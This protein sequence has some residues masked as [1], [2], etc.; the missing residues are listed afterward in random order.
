MTRKLFNRRILLINLFAAVILV[1]VLYL[2][3]RLLMPKYMSEIPEGALVSEYY[4]NKGDNDIIFIG[5]CEAYENI[6]PITIWENY[7][8][9]S[10]IIGSGQ[11]LIWQSYY[12]LEEVLRYETPDVVVFNILAMQYDKPQ[13]EPYNRLNIDGMKLGVPKVKAA[14]ASMM[15]EET[16]ASYI[17]PLL[18]YHSRWQEVT[19]EDFEYL[20]KRDQKSHNGFLMRVDVKPVE[21]IPQARALAD[22]QFGERSYEYLDKMRALCEQ[23]GIKLVLMKAP[24]LFP[25]WY[26]EWETQIEEYASSNGLLY[27][28]YLE[29]ADD[30]S[31]DFS[32]DT[33]DA[34]LH[35]NLS[36]AEKLSVHLGQVLQDE[37][38]LSDRRGEKELSES[39][40]DKVQFYYD[41]KA[42]QY[43]DLEKYGY[44][45]NFGGRAPQG[46]EES[47]EK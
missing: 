47:V 18:R 4:K 9:P 28:N 7:G 13:S 25:Y 46:S 30:I 26:P 23:N 33:Y 21:S 42:S 11:Q 1:I 12:M 6:S 8:V 16:L 10:Y 29:L 31:L 17:F 5:D 36:G 24:S 19:K 39:W 32:E 20:F 45:K 37:Y 38:N 3:Q 44:L 41:M 35:L 14:L 22:Y 27:L 40:Q 34:G 2:L 15:P 43:E